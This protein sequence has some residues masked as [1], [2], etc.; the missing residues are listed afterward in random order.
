MH[1]FAASF[2]LSFPRRTLHEQRIRHTN[3]GD[4]MVTSYKEEQRSAAS[5]FAPAVTQIRYEADAKLLQGAYAR[6]RA[7]MK[8]NG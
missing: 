7:T 4:S 5:E 6:L 1:P 2:L 3:V 8:M